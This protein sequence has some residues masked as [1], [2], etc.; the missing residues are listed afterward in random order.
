MAALY[1]R[2]QFDITLSKGG[3]TLVAECALAAAVI[4][5]RGGGTLV[6]ECALAAAVMP[7]RGGGIWW[8]SAGRAAAVIPTEAAERWWRDLSEQSSTAAEEASCTT[9]S[10]VWIPEVGS[11][12]T[13]VGT[14]LEL[15]ESASPTRRELSSSASTPMQPEG[16]A[17]S[18][19]DLDLESEDITDIDRIKQILG[20]CSMVVGMHPDQAA[21]EIIQFALAL[22]KPF[23]CVPCCTYSR[24]FPRRKFEGRQVT[25]YEDLCGYL[26]S[27]DPERI[28]IQELPFEEYLSTHRFDSCKVCM[29][30][31]TYGRIVALTTLAGHSA[32]LLP[33]CSRWGQSH[34]AA[35]MLA[36][37]TGPPCYQGFHM[38]HILS[39]V[40]L[41]KR[42]D[43]PHPTRDA[44]VKKDLTKAFLYALTLTE[45]G[46]VKGTMAVWQH[47]SSVE[48]SKLDGANLGFRCECSTSLV[49]GL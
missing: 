41:A 1:V 29:Q 17:P 35:N 20:G 27:L 46:T 48:V 33:A 23:A 4:P 5:H 10:P 44:Y 15:E 36:P 14:P 13:C 42:E 12:E 45:T 6:A 39:N 21:G 49:V 47:N 9:G 19:P 22:G 34:P 24:E 3:G 30:E 25:T 43:R 28:G 8:R 18:I 32:A 31:N 26:Q 16:P 7:H 37:C 40:L 11:K 38:N 2:P